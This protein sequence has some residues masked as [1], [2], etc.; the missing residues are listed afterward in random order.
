VVA[1]RFCSLCSA[2]DLL[3][4]C[5]FH[6]SMTSK[7]MRGYSSHCRSWSLQSLIVYVRMRVITSQF[8]ERHIVTDELRSAYN[9]V[10]SSAMRLRNSISVEVALL[11]LVVVAG[12]WIWRE[13]V[14]LRS[15]TWYAAVLPTPPP[16]VRVR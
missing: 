1:T 16:M 11:T 15:D 14:A 10:I 2:V 9:S 8:V 12:P 4:A 13:T 5:M 7:Y 3:V 6:S